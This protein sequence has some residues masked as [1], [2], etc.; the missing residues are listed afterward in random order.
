M[1]DRNE[2]NVVPVAPD[3]PSWLDQVPENDT[4]TE[5]MA[6]YRILSRLKI[7]QAQTDKMLR[8]KHGIG[9]IILHPA[10]VLVAGLNQPFNIT[11]LY[12]WTEY[13]KWRD[14]RDKEI[15][16]RLEVT[17]DKASDLARRAKDRDL[18]FETYAGDEGLPPK[19]QRTFRYVEHLNF[20]VVIN[21]LSHPNHGEICSLSYE[22]GSF[23]T[24]KKFISSIM[25]QRPNGV[26]APLY[27][28]IWKMG[29]VE[30]NGKEGDYHVLDF[31]PLPQD[32]RYVSGADFETFK[33]EHESLKAADEANALGM[34]EDS[35]DN[36]STVAD[37]L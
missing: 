17:R 4:S 35:A 16:A 23:F 22:R 13:A 33:R 31:E 27:A 18:R 6:E 32:E 30:V 20:A 9:S 3:A 21:D 36:E 28:Q 24:G 7:V 14:L 10:D 25:A 11:P 5:G 15:P 1:T 12:F 37:A 2:T 34:A 26:S 8:D 29:V 19:D